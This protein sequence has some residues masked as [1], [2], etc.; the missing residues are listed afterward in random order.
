MI[1]ATAD[2]IRA[3]SVR[4]AE[5]CYLWASHLYYVGAGS[6]VSDDDHD[7]TERMLELSRSEWS[8]YF[9]S[10]LAE[11]SRPLKTQAH[12]IRLSEEE[13]DNAHLWAGYV[14]FVRHHCQT[15]KVAP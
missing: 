11:P 2:E 12:A 9:K 15:K 14:E 13:I 8:D 6:P 1:T 10:H 5:M 4:F 3:S 7:A